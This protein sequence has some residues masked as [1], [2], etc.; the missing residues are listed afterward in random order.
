MGYKSILL[1][2][3]V[4]HGAEK[5]KIYILYKDYSTFNSLYCRIF[6]TSARYGIAM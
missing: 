6:P 4:V 5:E 2:D 3:D 1:T